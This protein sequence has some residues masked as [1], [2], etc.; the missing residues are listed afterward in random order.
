MPINIEG[1]EI[2]KFHFHII[3]LFL[4]ALDPVTTYEY[5]LV[6]NKKEKSQQTH[7]LFSTQELWNYRKPAA[8]FSFLIGG[9]SYL[10]ETIDE[11]PGKL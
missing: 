7:G 4:T 3:E 5:Q 6:V 10:N 2:D 9:C 8:D 11:R 1:K